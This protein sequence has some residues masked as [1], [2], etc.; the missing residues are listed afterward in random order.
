MSMVIQCISAAI[1]EGCLAHDPPAASR[2]DDRNSEAAAKTKICITHVCCL[3]I[4]TDHKGYS[5]DFTPVAATF[6]KEAPSAFTTTS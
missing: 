5:F 3:A 1:A 2:A 4:W 6:K